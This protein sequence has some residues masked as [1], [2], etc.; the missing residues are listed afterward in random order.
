MG[1]K[2]EWKEKSGW[3]LLS[4][5]T[6]LNPRL[7]PEIYLKR[8]AHS[9]DW[10]LDIMLKKKAVRSVARLDGRLVGVGLIRRDYSIGEGNLRDWWG[11][12]CPSWLNVWQTSPPL[13]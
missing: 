4:L 8:P 10:R 6:A 13:P 11:E 2:R 3:G 7:S 5:P 1:Q 12:T 9:N